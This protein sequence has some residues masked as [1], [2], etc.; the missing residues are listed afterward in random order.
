M[1]KHVVLVGKARE[2]LDFIRLID[3]SHLGGLRD[4]DDA[5]LGVVFIA[6][7]VVGVTDGIERDLAILVR[8]R[9]QL[10]S[11]VFFR[12]AALIGVDM[13]IIAAQDGVKWASEGLQAQNVRAGA[14]EGEEN[15]NVLA[16]V[17]FKFLDRGFGI[18]IGAVGHYVAMICLSYG[19]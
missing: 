6:Y 17:F 7:A 19:G 13:G 11:R 2:R 18:R 12:G 14:V 16:E 10:A 3:R 8:K 5:G 4:G 9:K 15:C 1:Q